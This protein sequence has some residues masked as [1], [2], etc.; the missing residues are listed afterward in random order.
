MS[1]RILL[2]AAACIAV[3]ATGGPAQPARPGPVPTNADVRAFAADFDA[4]L[5]NMTGRFPDLPSL[6]VV[7]TRSSGPRLKSNGNSASSLISRFIS[8]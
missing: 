3:L 2:A 1:K 7:V 8:A 5:V 6:T 4:F